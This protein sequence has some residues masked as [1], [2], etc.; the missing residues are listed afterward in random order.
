MYH[1]KRHGM[2]RRVP[3]T[4]DEGRE[5]AAKGLSFESIVALGRRRP[6]GGARAWRWAEPVRML[7]MTKVHNRIDGDLVPQCTECGYDDVSSGRW[8]VLVTH[9]V[10]QYIAPVR[11]R[12]SMSRQ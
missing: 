10:S 9:L 6:V 12:V 8:A 5:L 1:D 4:R 2:D 11:W 7:H 3:T